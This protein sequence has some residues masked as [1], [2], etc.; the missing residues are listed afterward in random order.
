MILLT[1]GTGFVGGHVLAALRASGRPRA[2]SR[3]EP[4]ESEPRVRARPGGHDRS[5]EPA[6]GRR[7]RG[8]GRPPGRDP[9]GQRREVR[10]DHGAGHARPARGSEGS[11]R[12]ALRP[13]ERARDERGV[14][15]PGALL[16]RQMGDG[17]GRREQR[18][19][20]RHLPAQLRLRAR[21]RHPPDVLQARALRAR[22]A[23]HRLG[24]AQAAADLGGRRGRL[25]RQGDRPGGRDEQ[26][27]RARRAGRRQLERVLGAAEEG[28]RDPS[29]EHPRARRRS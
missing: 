19:A 20:V 23:D 27:V 15:G 7:G 5:G 11:G 29:A 21:R 22:D 28:A 9:P 10:A 6:Q 2:L 16:R 12:Q 26:D 8:H 25:L 17:A 24:G 18:H 4:C 13:H 1:G 3:S 14:Q